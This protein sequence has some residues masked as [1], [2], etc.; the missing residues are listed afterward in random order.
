M[1]NEIQLINW[2]AHKE[3]KLKFAKGTNVLMG[4]MGAGKSSVLDAISY[5]LFGTY[6]AL[7]HK[8]SSAAGIIKNR[9]VQEQ[10]AVVRLSFSIGEDA[11]EVERRISLNGTTKATLL[12]NG[13]YLQSQ[14]QRVTE[15][16]EKALKVEY[17]L[18]SRAVYS[19]QNRLD[20]FLELRAADRKSQIDELLGLDRFSTAIENSTTLINRFKDMVSDQEAQIA[21]LDMTKI[22]SQRDSLKNER[23]AL[24]KEKEKLDSDIG[25][26]AAEFARLEEELRKVKDMYN[27]K[28]MLSKEIA[29]AKSRLDFLRG[30][31]KKIEE[32]R[33]GDTAAIE[34][35]V[36]KA[37]DELKKLKL[38]E[39]RIR[40]IET[41]AHK[42]S[43]RAAA[44]ISQI[45]E[46]IRER[47][48]LVSE[49]G[50]RKVQEAEK[51]LE[52]KIA[53]AKK[54]EDNI[55]TLNAQKKETEGWI[56]ELEK[57]ITKCPVCEREL[58]EEMKSRLLE[59]KRELSKKLGSMAE[60]YAKSLKELNKEIEGAR[61][62]LYKLK[63][64]I[65]RIESFSDLD[66]QL[67][68]A[69]RDAERYK[70]DEAKVKVDYEDNRR[71]IEA[72]NE[73]LNVLGSELE[74][75]KR[76]SSYRNDEKKIAADLEEKER[77]YSGI[78][79]D[80]E[81]MEK[82]QAL[83]SDMKAEIS[84]KRAEAEAAKKYIE[85]KER[86]IADKEEQI[87]RL[88]KVYDE[89]KREKKIVEDVQK[90]KN[91]LT[92]TQGVLRSKLINS[93]N[94]VMQ[95]IW[96]EMYPYGDYSSITL[97]G[98]SSDYVLKLKT[99]TGVWEEV[100]A[101]ASGGERSIACLA[102]RVAFAMVLVP[103]LRWII[104]DEPT[105]NIDRQ[106]LAMFAQVFNETLPRIIDQVFIITHDEFLRQAANAKV[107]ILSRNKDEDGAT[108]VEEA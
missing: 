75:A 22:S 83:Y 48:R 99:S 105:H 37:T 2:K 54:I 18:F 104:L 25:R 39:A 51:E 102:M 93:I 78:E 86:Q 85:E 24:V 94:S 92:E 70:A 69:K 17:D 64:D 32:K 30:E 73:R 28:N 13:V 21:N 40:S 6:P 72:V 52:E 50:G 80:E 101:I 16:I 7:Q 12:K 56:A 84:K 62:S 55:A 67:D 41:D 20:Y 35:E 36:A 71:Q 58:T 107:Y 11:Y 60:D 77:V 57:H 88:N 33:L 3:T 1:I 43:A 34:S 89:I 95:E 63:S 44:L 87:E 108:V 8:R 98:T 5:A 4:V 26:K 45:E 46:K 65:S 96:P 82:M 74:S 106:G 29:E 47:D 66:A 42:N 68:A 81:K 10:E 91:A 103:N 61:D 23:D 79:I 59:G 14:P 53:S 15:E 19:E 97:E 100:N 27:R 76:L 9:P 38:E 31:I 90:F 49:V